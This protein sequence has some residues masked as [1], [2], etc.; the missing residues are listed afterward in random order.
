MEVTSIKMRPLASSY[1]RY[2]VSAEKHGFDV[3][4]NVLCGSRLHSNKQSLYETEPSQDT[5]K[6]A[7]TWLPLVKKK[8][9]NDSKCSVAGRVSELNFAHSS[10]CL[11]RIDTDTCVF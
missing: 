7:Y 9:K 11:S 8:E 1:A 2:G 3:T 6:K 5:H 10:T 4:E